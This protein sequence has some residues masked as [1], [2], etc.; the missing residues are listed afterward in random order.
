MEETKEIRAFLRSEI[1]S[2]CPRVP[3]LPLPEVRIITA[4]FL[5]SLLARFIHL[6]LYK[7]ANICLVM[8]IW[9]R[10]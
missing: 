5:L 4:T 2:P 7:Q 9:L 10:E 8:I 6:G 3:R 1:L